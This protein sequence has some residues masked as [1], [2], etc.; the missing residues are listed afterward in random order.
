MSKSF[1]KDSLLKIKDKII[2]NRNS[3]IENDKKFIKAQQI[4][5]DNLDKAN[6]ELMEKY[7]LQTKAIP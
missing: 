4:E 3:V 5:F 7:K 1:E 2:D 6:R